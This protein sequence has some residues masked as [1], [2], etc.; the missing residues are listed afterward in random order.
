M[1]IFPQQNLPTIPPLGRAGPAAW[2]VLSQRRRLNSAGPAQSRQPDVLLPLLHP[3]LGAPV[4]G[5]RA[6]GR[7]LR[8]LLGLIALALLVG[9]A[10]PAIAANQGDLILNEFNAVSDTKFLGGKGF[11]GGNIY[12]DDDEINIAS[13]AYADQQGPLQLTTTGTMPEG[14]SFGTD[15]YI[16]NTGL[17]NSPASDWIG[18]SL[19]PG[20]EKVDIETATGGIHTLFMGDS[21]LGFF[22][23]NGGNWIELVVVADH[24]DIRG[25]TLEW[26]NGD[27]D[28]GRVSF[29]SHSI[30]SDLRSGTIITIREDDL[31]P[32]GYGRLLSDLSYDPEN[33]DWWIHANVDDAT[34]VTQFGF[35]TDNDNWSMRIWD[36]AVTCP[37]PPS[38]C[39]GVG[40]TAVIQDWVG[41]GTGLWGGGGGVGSDE[42]GKLEQDPS[43]AAATTPP[44]PMYNDGTSS[45]YGSENLWAT[46]TILQD[47]SALRAVIAV[48][49]PALTTKGTVVV[50]GLL[51]S[52][53]F[54]LARRK[55]PPPPSD[56]GPMGTCAGVTLRRRH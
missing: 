46:G 3:R 32:P 36:G 40:P 54:W 45:T 35:K 5:T 22:Q 33:G 56:I 39:T 6:A 2:D 25:W 30:W 11:L 10:D 7:G 38:V 28:Q 16:V 51:L 31:S 55:A 41:E 1:A 13:H 12:P 48:A 50:T 37:A 14:L 44:T 23:G 15:Y 26:H 20:G 49:V 19:T 27:P 9:S 4:D 24:L 18:L 34:V 17:T 53:V 47:F 29:Q 21:F 43:A 52:S 42:V 8:G